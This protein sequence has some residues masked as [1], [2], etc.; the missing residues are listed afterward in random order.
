MGL[1]SISLLSNQ[2]TLATCLDAC[3][4]IKY[5]NLNENNPNIYAKGI[6]RNPRKKKSKINEKEESISKSNIKNL[7]SW[8]N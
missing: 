2:T 7:K 3:D 8:K 1:F 6:I 4:T 5:Y